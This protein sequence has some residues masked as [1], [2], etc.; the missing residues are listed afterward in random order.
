MT[1]ISP[2][3][4]EQVDQQA[5]TYAEA[6]S[7]AAFAGATTQQ[8]QLANALVV[9]NS[10]PYGTF[11][12]GP[13]ID[14]S[15]IPDLPGVLLE[16]GKYNKSVKIITGHCSDEGLLFTSPFVQTNAQYSQYLQQLFPNISSHVLSVITDVLYPPNFN[17]SFGYTS[18]MRRLDLAIG[19]YAIV[20]NASYLDDAF[21]GQHVYKFT[22]PPRTHAEDTSY[23]FYDSGPAPGVHTSLAVLL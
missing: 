22:I 18:Q 5:L 14:G 19:D 20:C 11:A 1:Y 23:I 10:A 3:Q 6:T 9:G 16:E 7:Y 2:E 8:L 12:F 15:Y 13:V 4:Q 17:G 21:K